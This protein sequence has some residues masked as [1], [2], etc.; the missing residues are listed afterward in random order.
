M[1][2]MEE[3]KAAVKARA[4]EELKVLEEKEVLQKAVADLDEK[5]E[6]Q[7]KVIKG[8]HVVIAELQTKRDELKPPKK[9]TP[10]AETPE[11]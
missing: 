5:I 7:R 3:R 9:R 8:A 6:L 1:K 11:V 10:K 4:D 2:T